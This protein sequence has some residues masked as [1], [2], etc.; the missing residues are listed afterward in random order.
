MPSTLELMGLGVPAQQAGLLG[1]GADSGTLTATGSS[2]TDA[3]QLTAGIN[4]FGTVA[5]STGCTLP[6]NDQFNGIVAVIN[7]G[8]NA[9]LVY[10][11]TGKQVNNG[12]VSTGGYSV[13]NGK[14][15]LFIRSG[16]RWLAT[17]ST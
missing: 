17:L 7:G 14:T 16:S 3:L 1:F 15:A 2:S 8:A 5:A 9:L 13:A 11:G 12:T 4:I 10:P 6:T